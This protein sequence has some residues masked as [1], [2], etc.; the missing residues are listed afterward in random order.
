MPS[1]VASRDNLR[2]SLDASVAVARAVAVLGCAGRIAAVAAAAWAGML[3]VI[4]ILPL[5]GGPSIGDRWLL[6]AAAAAAALAS[7]PLFRTVASAW[8]S[9][10]A[11]AIAA[12]RMHPQLG[13]SISRA[14]EFLEDKSETAAPGQGSAALRALA[15]ERA[16]E[17]AAGIGRLP[18]P[19]LRANLLSAVSGAVAV[20]LVAAVTSATAPARTTADATRGLPAATTVAGVP[21]APRSI[22][23]ATRAVWQRIE[24]LRGR[25]AGENP[26]TQIGRAHV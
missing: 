3:L 5:A 20:A 1:T 6:V 26:P 2:Q 25:L 23:A 7:L 9:R 19:G 12:E 13:E 16:A 4:R 17:A 8:P 11:I 21:A 15:A 14:I 22:A 18:V 24:S 10:L